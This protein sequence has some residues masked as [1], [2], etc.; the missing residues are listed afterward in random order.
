VLYPYSP[1]GPV[2]GLLYYYC[3]PPKGNVFFLNFIV[4]K[5]I[6]WNVNDFKECKGK[7]TFISVHVMKAYRDGRFSS[8]DP[9]PWH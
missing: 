1:S 3:L 8:M 9:Q 7:G 6:R 4:A 2:T 5:L